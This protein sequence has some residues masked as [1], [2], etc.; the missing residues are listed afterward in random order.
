MTANL[1][2]RAR[3]QLALV[4][5]NVARENAHDLPG[6]VVVPLC[7]IFCFM[8]REGSPVSAFTTTEEA[9]CNRWDC[10][11]ILNPSSGDS[12][13]RSRIRLPWLAPMGTRFSGPPPDKRPTMAKR[14]GR[15]SIS[16]PDKMEAFVEAQVSQEGY[17]SASEYLRALIREALKQI[18][19]AC[20]DFTRLEVLWR[21][22]RERAADDTC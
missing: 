16:V 13:L 17:A 22:A 19:C 8:K 7:G 11:T 4:E 2:T 12:K 5:E 21:G 10:I 6:I 14:L 3:A 20:V 18:S 15:M 1:S 9:R